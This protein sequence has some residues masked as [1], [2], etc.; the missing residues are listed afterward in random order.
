[1]AMAMAMA[2]GDGDGDST[3]GDGDG[4]LGNCS[5]SCANV[6]AC[7]AEA[8]SASPTFSNLDECLSSCLDN[9]ATADAAGCASDYADVQS[10]I[11]TAPCEELVVYLATPLNASVCTAETSA[12]IACLP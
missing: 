2:I 1:M 3:S 10:C 9:Y 5:A 12:Y 4:D 6:D 8:Y 7:G 11:A